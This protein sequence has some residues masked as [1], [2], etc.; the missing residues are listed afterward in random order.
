MISIK[1]YNP[2]KIYFYITL[3]LAVS[4]PLSIF[5]TSVAE[6]ALI[7]NWL[8]EAKFYQKWQILRRRKAVIFIVS[9]YLL[10]LIGLLYTESFNFGYAIHDLKI[11]LS[12]LLLPIIFATSEA[13]NKRQ[14]K[15]ILILFSIATLSSALIGIMVFFGII[16]VEHYDFRDISIFISN[17]RLSLMVNLSFF[18]LAYYIFHR[19]KEYR[20]KFPWNISAVAGIILLLVFLI[21]L[22]SITGLF[23][24]ILLTLILGWYFSSEIS[25]IAPR[26]IIRV[27]V[28]TLPLVIASFISHSIGKFYYTPELV[29]SDLEE[30][31][32]E[33][34][35][36]YH[37]TLQKARENGNY[38][39]IYI[40]EEELRREWNKL[41]DLKYD[42]W[43]NKKQRIKY[44]L[45]RYL[46][47]KGERKDAHGIASL[48]EADILAIEN[49]KANHIFN[50]KFGLYPRIYEIIWE[51]DGYLSG[52]DPS[53]HSVAQRI[54]YLK[55][56]KAIIKQHW[57]IGV[58]TGD[59]Q[60]SFN[61]HYENSDSKLDSN[62]RRRAHNQYITFILSFGVVGFF[63]FVFALI[64]PVFIEKRWKDYLF[65]VF[66]F[67]GMI[68]MLN[69]D[70][71]ETQTGV[72]FFIFFYSLLMF[73]REGNEENDI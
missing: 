11:K 14:L 16:P 30:Y 53:G 32:S 23:I 44:T 52:G 10:H 69:E 50:K 70:T 73:A 15:W 64:A 1:I 25:D 17:I 19:D 62:Y 41:S 28:I 7:V 54:A 43:D 20:L 68:S 35:L 67:I 47:S 42:D 48:S 21:L 58:G 59:V 37:D 61:Q 34:N 4:L 66:F 57:L 38:V 33:G 6:I 55:A 46:T 26:F 36:Y 65:M 51:I 18:I 31:S 56:A 3:L 40:N 13:F 27:M 72:S 24:L 39:W 2:R 9:I 63:I 29:F 22:K 12:I 8:L 45:I 60:Y 71:L 5:T 49:G